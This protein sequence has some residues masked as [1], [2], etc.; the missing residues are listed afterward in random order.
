MKAKRIVGI[1]IFS[2]GIG[3]LVYL[4]KGFY[5]PKKQ[6]ESMTPDQLKKETKI[7]TAT[8]PKV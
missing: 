7:T 3:A 6:V 1:A 5:L 2:I 8:T 4:Y